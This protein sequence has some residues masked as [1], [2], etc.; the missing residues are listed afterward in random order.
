MNEQQENKYR[1]NIQR[2]R[3]R[4]QQWAKRQRRNARIEKS[5]LYWICDSGLEEVYRISPRETEQAYRRM[6]IRYFFSWEGLSK[7]LLAPVFKVGLTSVIVTPFVASVYISLQKVFGSFFTHKF[8]I[9]MGLLFL[10]G[11]SVVIARVFYELFC[12]K[13]VKAHITGS[14]LDSQNLQND[15]WLQ[16]E[17]EHCLLHYVYALPMTEEYVRAKQMSKMRERA[18]QVADKPPGWFVEV[19]ELAPTRVG[20]NKYGIWLIQNLL[21]R[22]AKETDRKL[23]ISWTIPPQFSERE[24]S[25]ASFD[26]SY[27]AIHGVDL[28][29]AYKDTEEL[30]EI[31]KGDFLLQI[32]EIYHQVIDNFPKN[33]VIHNYFNGIYVITNLGNNDIV[34]EFIAEN[35]NYWKPKS[36]IV[37]AVLLSLSLIFLLIF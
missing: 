37:I 21:L 5:K 26:T 8:P 1:I 9:Q 27:T 31:H 7:F 17:L 28:K 15:Q 22:I 29:V 32:Y 23:F 13:M 30:E 34:K 3:E 33:A 20:F 4:C 35:E 25:A 36:R 14:A 24:S 12:P 6:R 16:M 10:A 11:L 2:W 18:E 19:P